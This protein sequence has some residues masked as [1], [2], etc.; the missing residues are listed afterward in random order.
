MEIYGLFGETLGH[1]LSPEI[2]NI[3]FKKYNI[4]GTYSLFEIKKSDFKQSIESAKILGLSGVNVTIPYKIDV[5][6]QLD[7]VD[8]SVEKIGAC[9]CVKFS[10][11]EDRIVAKGFNTDYYGVLDAFNYNDV[12]VVGR[13]C[14]VLGSG[15]ASKSV[16]TLLKDLGANTITIVKREIG[17]SVD[18]GNIKYI[19]YQMLENI[20][21]SYLLVNTTP[22]GMYPNIS[23]SPVEKE[24][25]KK[26]EVCFDAVYNPI[27]TKLLREAKESGLKTIDGLYMLVGQAINAFSLYNDIDVSSYD[28][29]EI[30]N[31]VLELLWKISY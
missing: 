10:K 23:N 20:E 2:Y 3:L 1:S 25:L 21:N 24:I 18:S 13:D 6:A 15:G 11:L 19:N 31:K 16:V 8:N 5:I 28:F 27:E 9:N 17:D 12:D 7:I 29:L 30:Y 22:I 26:F 4:K 14:V